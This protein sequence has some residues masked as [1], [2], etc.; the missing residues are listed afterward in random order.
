[1]SRFGAFVTPPTFFEG[2]PSAFTSTG[3]ST[4]TATCVSGT[5]R[6]PMAGRRLSPASL[7]PITARPRRLAGSGLI[8]SRGAFGPTP[9]GPVGRLTCRGGGALGGAN[10]NA[11]APKPR[12][13][14]LTWAGCGGSKGGARLFLAARPSPSLSAA[15]R[16][17]CRVGS[18]IARSNAFSHTFRLATVGSVG[19]GGRLITPGGCVLFGGTFSTNA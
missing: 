18:V 17:S 15:S 14:S 7:S 3:A 12:C 19:R 9:I 6:A 13:A 8:P 16:G 4:P 5:L 11:A 1:M 10:G 2:R